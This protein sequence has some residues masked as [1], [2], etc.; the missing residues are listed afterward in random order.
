MV[1]L[2]YRDEPCPIFFKMKKKKSKLRKSDGFKEIAFSTED[3]IADKNHLAKLNVSDSRK[4][5][6]ETNMY[7]LR[8]CANKYEIKCLNFLRS[9]GVKVIHQAPFVLDDKMYF[10][11]IYVP[12]KRTIIEIDGI[13]H[14]NNFSAEYDEERDEAFESLMYKIIRLQNDVTT[15]EKKLEEALASVI[16]SR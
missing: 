8:Q 7:R 11:D 15:D 9:R 12:S 3:V 6:I 4:D 14:D 5:W 16:C 10:A 1:I 13:A 2:G